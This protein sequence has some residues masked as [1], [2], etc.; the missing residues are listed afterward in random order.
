MATRAT[1]PFSA[2]VTAPHHVRARMVG[3]RADRAE[4]RLGRAL[5]HEATT[6]Y[7]PPRRKTEAMGRIRP[8][9]GLPLFFFCFYLNKF[10]K[11][12]QTSKIHRNL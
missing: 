7:G 9:R 10:Q 6:A 4:L 3:R 5:G 12:F 2:V 11:L 1:A 8:M